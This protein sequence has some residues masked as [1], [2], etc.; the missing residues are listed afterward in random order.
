MSAAGVP[1]PQY[2][3]I[4]PETCM[5]C[6]DGAPVHFDWHPTRA[7][8][9]KIGQEM[10]ARA[11]A[12]HRD[13]VRLMTDEILIGYG[14]RLRRQLAQAAAER[15]DEVAAGLVAEWLADVEKE[16]KWRTRAATLGGP[17]VSR[18][19]A[20]WADRA[21]AV[22]RGT[23]LVWLIC[24]DAYDAKPIGTKGW[25]V[26]C[27]FHNDR[28]PSMDVDTEKHVWICRACSLGGDA[29]TFVELKF[30]LSFV[31]A[32]RYL[33]ER[34]G[35]KPAGVTAFARGGRRPLGAAIPV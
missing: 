31:E 3:Y 4:P 1:V 17:A 15:W 12:R 8:L 24:F 32:V 27:P 35:I 34:L 23:D 14:Q 26:A 18:S 25:R 11:R 10:T 5:A 29:I 16:W 21:E 20:S 22:K 7:A 28:H 13:E 2:E 33:E 30:N 19:G 9:L 6:Y